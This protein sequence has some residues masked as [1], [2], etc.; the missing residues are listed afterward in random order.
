MKLISSPA[1]ADGRL[2]ERG[3]VIYLV[4]FLLAAALCSTGCHKG[5]AGRAGDTTTPVDPH[6]QPP[7]PVVEAPATNQDDLAGG[8]VNPQPGVPAAV[9][10][11]SDGRPL[12]KPNGEPDLHVM[13]RA[14][15]DWRFAHQRKPSTFQEFA[16]SAGIVIPRPPAGK[17]YALA[18]SG[19]IILINQ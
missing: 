14:L 15:L 3:T 11:Y 13:D 9:P 12:V 16:A 10:T 5:D 1:C 7:P 18:Q 17:K 19:H 6:T 2:A 8:V 4:G